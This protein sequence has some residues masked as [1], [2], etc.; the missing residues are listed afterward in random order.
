MIL[1]TKSQLQAPNKNLPLLVAHCSQTLLL[2]LLCFECLFFLLSVG[3]STDGEF[4]QLRR[5]GDTHLLHIWQLA[6]DAHDSVSKM[7]ETTLLQLLELQG[8]IN[9]IVSVLNTVGHI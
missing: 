1:L 2:K 5:R 9:S 4:E 6:H 8:V 7:S 3:T